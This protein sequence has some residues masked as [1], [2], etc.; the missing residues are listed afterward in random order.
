M[1]SLVTVGPLIY[2]LIHPWHWLTYSG[3]ASA[4]GLIVVVF[5]TI[6]TRRM[7]LL[8]QQT[9]RGELYPI[10]ALQEVIVKNG[11]MDLVIVNVGA[12]PLIN[13]SQ[14]GQPVSDR[15]ELGGT[16]FERPPT[17]GQSFGGSML[18]GEGR[19]LSIQVDGSEPRVLLVLEGTDSVG[20]R[21]QFCLLRSRAASGKYEHQVRM[22]HPVDFLPFWRRGA[23]KLY[24][25][26]ARLQI[27][28]SKR[29]G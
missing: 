28:R 13:A 29:V 19:T 21:H 2:Q 14:W 4:V 7:M 27:K 3:N 26:R 25:W 17:I 18:K 1:T 24:E 6:Y 22:V 12:G 10:I 9:R 8:A 23:W 11:S 16:F 20:G 15:F 5:Y